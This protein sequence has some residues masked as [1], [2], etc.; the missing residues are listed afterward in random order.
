MRERVIKKKKVVRKNCCKLKKILAIK[1][2]L[3]V[4]QFKNAN[5]EKNLHGILTMKKSK[6]IFIQHSHKLLATKKQ[7]NFFRNKLNHM[8]FKHMKICYIKFN[9]MKIYYLTFQIKNSPHKQV[10][11]QWDTD[12]NAFASFQRDFLL[13]CV[14]SKKH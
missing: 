1:N 10:H 5:N 6:K 4:F 2:Q 9:H 7:R 8:K 14:N 11:I 12:K 3:K 13:F